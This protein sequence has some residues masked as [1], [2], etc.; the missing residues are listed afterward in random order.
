M[1]D[2][3][4]QFKILGGTF[5]TFLGTV[6]AW[7]TSAHMIISLIASI[8]AVIVGIMTA[9]TL[10]KRLEL[11]DLEQE[12]KKLEIRQAKNELKTKK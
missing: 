7:T 2:P 4:E 3:I 9:R 6:T 8:V 10:I 12:L 5:I 11:Q 1:I